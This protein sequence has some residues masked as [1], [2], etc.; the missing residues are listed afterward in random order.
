VLY[1]TRPTARD[2]YT[3]AVQKNGNIDAG[4]AR[5]RHLEEQL[6]RTRVRTGRH[7][8]FAKSIRIEAGLYRKSLDNAQAARRF[9]ARPALPVTGRVSRLGVPMKSRGLQ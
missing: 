7:R 4:L 8:E 2:R 6:A 1:R 5:I 9:A 3:G